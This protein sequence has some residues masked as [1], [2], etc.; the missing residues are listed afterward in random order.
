MYR[1]LTWLALER[2]ADLD[3][4]E[5]LGALAREHPID[6]DDEQHVLIDGRDV[7]AEIREP[8]IDKSFRRRAPP[9]RSAR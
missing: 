5:G 9:R 7:S 2:D 3:D 8:R 6:F 4:A 1:A